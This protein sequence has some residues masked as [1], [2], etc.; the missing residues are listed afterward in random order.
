[1]RR[2]CRRVRSLLLRIQQLFDRLLIVHGWNGGEVGCDQ[3]GI[4]LHG[5]DHH[6]A[7]LDVLGEL[8]D[9]PAA[10]GCGNL[11][12]DECA[13]G[14]EVREDAETEVDA[15]KEIC[16]KPGEVM[17]AG[18]NPAASFEAGERL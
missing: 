5:F 2:R 13:T 3:L 4:F 16:L 10:I 6:G 1:M 7:Y 11:L 17:G 15:L 9:D 8:P 14:I 12:E 18:I